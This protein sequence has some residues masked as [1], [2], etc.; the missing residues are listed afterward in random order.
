MRPL[1]D[2]SF[3]KGVCYGMRRNDA[4][5]LRELGYAKRLGI[6]S[7]RIWLSYRAFEEEGA[8]YIA[9]L[10]HFVQLCHGEGFSVVPILFNGN[11]MDPEMLKPAFYKRGDAFALAVVEALHSE[12]GL[13]MYDIMNEPPCNDLIQKAPDTDTQNRIYE[14]IWRFVRRY[15]VIVKKADPINAITVGNWYANQ[16]ETSA[17]LVDVLS[18]HD[19]SPTLKG[20]R[21]NAELALSIGRKYRKC[22]INNETCCIARANPYD[23]VIETLSGY[24]IPWYV[25]NLMIDGYWSDVHGIFY[26]D[27]TVRD[28]AIAAAI[29]GCFRKRDI[30]T[31]VPEKANRE[32]EAVNSLKRL[33]AILADSHPDV[34]SYGGFDTEALLEECETMANLLEGGQLVAMQV[35][36]SARIAAFRAQEKPSILEIKQ[37]AYQLAMQ[38]KEG[39]QIL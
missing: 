35:P 24:G 32:Q 11:G 18:Y 25:F 36:P 12:P 9:R 33:S 22:V 27:G 21:E 37:F 31:M 3:I 2:Y 4:D 10:K 30:P 14:K 26:P 6:N 17:D 16:M 7:L 38:L 13:L 8:A 39:C 34:F 28:P 19:Y 20:V 15:C 23:R 29:V 5:A 1:Q